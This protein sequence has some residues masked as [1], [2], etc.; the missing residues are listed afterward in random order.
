MWI[1]IRSRRK[2]FFLSFFFFKDKLPKGKEKM[3]REKMWTEKK[4]VIQ[5]ERNACTITDEKN[6]RDLRVE[7]KQV[8]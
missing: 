6:C 1:Q 8:N 3:I 7:I 4:G 5:N 2:K